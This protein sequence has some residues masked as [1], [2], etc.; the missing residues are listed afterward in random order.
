GFLAP[1]SVCNNRSARGIISEAAR[2][3]RIKRVADL[4][5]R[6]TAFRPGSERMSKTGVTLSARVLPS[7]RHRS[8]CA[9]A[10][11]CSRSPTGLL[12]PASRLVRALK[13]TGRRRIPLD[14]LRRYF[15]AACPELAEQPDRRTRLAEALQSAADTGDILLPRGARSWDRAGGAPLPGFVTLAAQPTPAP[16]IESGYSW[17]PLLKFAASERNRLRLQ[18][19]RRVNE[20]LKTDPDLTLIAPI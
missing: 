3:V 1:N 18:A 15:A 5:L 19:A 6:R 10:I 16:A 2:R 9:P 13:K 8:A 4:S 14:M 20:W 7:Q 11:I 17:H 12:E